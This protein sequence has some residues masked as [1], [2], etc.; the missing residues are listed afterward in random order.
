MAS[1]TVLYLTGIRRV[2]LVQNTSDCCRVIF[3]MR[4]PVMFQGVVWFI[5]LPGGVGRWKVCEISKVSVGSLR[6]TNNIHSSTG[7]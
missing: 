7:E 5:R 6:K 1:S 4:D 3:L 2:L